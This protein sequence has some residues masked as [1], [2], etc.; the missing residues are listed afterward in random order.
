MNIRDKIYE[1]KA[2]GK[3]RR[4]ELEEFCRTLDL[5]FK[6]LNMLDLAFHHRSFSNEN[7]EHRHYNNERLEFLG[8][9]VLGLA[10]AS[11]L[12]E[13]MMDNPE[14]DLARIKANVVSEQ[15]LA[16]IALEKMHIDRYLILGKGEE[17][18]GGRTKKAILADAVEA[19]I[20]ALYLDSGFDDAA[21]LVERLIVPEIRK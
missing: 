15:T 13:D 4:K 9:S 1:S 12:Y 3:E 14:G 10:V 20:G 5:H 2:L 6:N 8:D 19:V 16:P 21:Q 11:F 7:E 18:T 17:M